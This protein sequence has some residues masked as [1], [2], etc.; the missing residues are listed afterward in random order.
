MKEALGLGGVEELEQTILNK[1]AIFLTK[2]NVDQAQLKLS[3]Y[4]RMDMCLTT[5]RMERSH[6]DPKVERHLKRRRL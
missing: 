3:L 5:V 2:V 4:F 6:H 1:A